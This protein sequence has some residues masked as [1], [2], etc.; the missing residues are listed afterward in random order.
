MSPF[1][2]GV[3]DAGTFDDTSDVLAPT[4]ILTTFLKKTDPEVP[5]FSLPFRFIDKQA[6]PGT[7]KAVAVEE[8][9]DVEEVLHCVETILRY[10]R[11]FRIDDPDFGTPDQLFTLGGANADEI[12]A[13]IANSEPRVEALV[14]VDNQTL[15]DLISNVLVTLRE[16]GD[17]G[18]GVH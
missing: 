15:E 5:H 17:E 2:S 7:V 14:E 13:A 16:K 1:D 8:Q 12:K 4:T 9:D 11:G 10:P 6:S 18:A 3:F